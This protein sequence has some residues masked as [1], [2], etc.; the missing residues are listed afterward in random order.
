[1]S[2]QVLVVP[3][4]RLDALGRFDG[5]S[6]D[7]RYFGALADGRFVDRGP[8]ERDESQRQIIPYVVIRAP[9]GVFSYARTGAGREAR[10][11][12]RRSIGVGGHV[13]PPDLPE[14]LAALARA[15]VE[16]LAAAAR[17][18]LAEETVGLDDARLEWLGFLRDESAPV[19]RV[20]FGV[21]FLAELPRPAVHLTDEGAMDD[22][23]WQSWADLEADRSAYEGWSR[24]VIQHMARTA[25]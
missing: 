17:R 11:H 20:H 9:D 16:T 25:R 14:G 4:A 21:V 7:R 6:D 10:L 5:F 19:A 23:R 15:P 1:M 18:E 12:G 2:E 22:P 24:L 8:A 3:T 13:N